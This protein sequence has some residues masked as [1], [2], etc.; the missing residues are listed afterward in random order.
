MTQP[1]AY[2]RLAPFIREYIYDKRW[3]ALREIQEKTIPAILDT[4]DHLLIAAGTASGK[5]EAAF[6][7]ILTLLASEPVREEKGI[8]V[9]Y[10]SPLKALI[11]DQSQRLMPL[12]D[13]AGIPLRR[14]HGDVSENHKQKALEDPAGI[15]QITPE[16]LEAL[17]LRRHEKIAGLF[18]NLKFIVIDEVHAFMGTDRGAQLI[19]LM[20]RI[21]VLS[22]S[23]PRRV[24]LSATL[25]DYSAALHWLGRGTERRAVLIRGEMGQGQRVS[26]AVD[27]YRDQGYYP[28]LYEQCRGVKKCIIFTNSRLEAE[29]TVS[30][31]KTL[32]RERGGEDHFHVHHGSIA[33]S[34]RQD[35]ERA[36]KEKEGPVTTAATATLELGIDI[37]ELDR[38]IQIGPPA[39][40]ANFVQRLG[41]SG[42]SGGKAQMYFTHREFP[43]IS[44]GA[45]VTAT[46]I[47]RIP[48]GLLQTIAV[49]QLY[50]E[51]QWTEDAGERPLPFSLLCHQTLSVLASLGERTAAELSRL[52][53]S[54][55]PF[56][57]IRLEDFA[58]LL[59]SLE[60]GG[61][62]EKIVEETGE[63]T[64]DGKIILGLEGE[65]IVNHYSF[66][67]VFPGEDEFR[68]TFDGRELGK[69]NFIPPEKS[70]IILGG[71]AW[72]VETVNLRGR[73]IIVTPGTG[74]GVRIWRGG[75]APVHGRVTGR[76]R[77]VLR[78]KT[79]YRYLS[80]SAADRLDEA[81]NLAAE[82][83]LAESVFFRDPAGASFLI[84]WLGSRGMRTLLLLLQA[85]ETRE[86]L[87]LVSVERENEFALR[88]HTKLSGEDFMGKL[89]GIIAGERGESG[90]SDSLKI[91]MPKIPASKIPLTEK[92]DYLLPPE[93]LLKQ[94]AANMLDWEELT[95][96]R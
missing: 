24:G 11:N 64:E 15:L 35:T 92:F 90:G 6:F 18:G 12:A 88:L 70:G 10:I 19:C 68:V 63:E 86:N 67:S 58:E 36:L 32:A 56:R 79:R 62:V 51:E 39:G 3:Q 33:A 76:M 38:I 30:A 52:I 84:P 75:G 66:Y 87:A 17:L 82:T 20:E 89:R 91:P 93:L 71:R 2:S 81:R 77:Q 7:P 31:L 1:S 94:F 22:G 4:E 61:F 85:K 54:F 5:T 46:V 16:S 57:N 80:P 8:A 13:R 55:P 72:R 23:A 53:L 50:L 25:G 74:G 78:E 34:L 40:A 29:E 28:A 83:G 37:G 69:I 41:R 60:A 48:W 27:Y 65:R 47:E 44:P 95:S 21:R 59:R 26:L 43:P 14:W 45:A 73:E 96:L 42:R 49:I 9:L